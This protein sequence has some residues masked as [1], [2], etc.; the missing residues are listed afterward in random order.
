MEVVLD[1]VSLKRLLRQPK[2]SSSQNR[3]A[4]NQTI[5]DQAISDGDL[6]LALDSDDGLLNEW[7]VTCGE[8]IVKMLIVKWE[9]SDGIFFIENLQKLSASVRKNLRQQNFTGTI[10]KLILRISISTADKK[11]VSDDSDFWDPRDHRQTGNATASVAN[12]LQRTLDVE[13]MLLRQLV[14]RI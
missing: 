13:V 7:Q 9:T 12:Y 5:L 11:I 2:K 8:E 6:R 10:D 4:K 1:T 14:E 3:N